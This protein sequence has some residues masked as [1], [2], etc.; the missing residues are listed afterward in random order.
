MKVKD[1]MTTDVRT[2]PS[3]RPSR[4]CYEHHGRTHQLSLLSISQLIVAKEGCTLEQANQI[5]R[6][7]KKGKLPV[8]NEKV[9]TACHV[10]LTCIHDSADLRLIAVRT[11]RRYLAQRLAQEPRLPPRLEG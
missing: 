9:W 6:D 2:R 10:K 1:V 5:L 7:S 3:S 11:R 4:E 8:V